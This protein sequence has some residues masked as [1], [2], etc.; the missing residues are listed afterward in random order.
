MTPSW[1]FDC[2]RMSILKQRLRLQIDWHQK[3]GHVVALGTRMQTWR[4]I[5]KEL[6]RLG[7]KNGYFQR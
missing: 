1:L 4:L 2:H 5:E 7:R 6:Q 3:K